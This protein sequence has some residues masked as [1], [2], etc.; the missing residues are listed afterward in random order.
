MTTRVDCRRRLVLGGMLAA[1]VAAAVTLSVRALDPTEADVALPPD[2]ALVPGS[3]LG[4]VEVRVA[5]LLAGDLGQKLQQQLPKESAAARQ[6]VVK[7]IGVA[8]EEVERAVLVILSEKEQIPLAVITTRQPYDREKVLSAVL[9]EHQQRQVKGQTYYFSTKGGRTALRFLTDRVYVSGPVEDVVQQMVKRPTAPAQNPLRP[10]LLLAAQKHLIAAGVHIPEAAAALAKTA[11]DRQ[12][13]NGSF[14]SFVGKSFKPLL[15]VRSVA[16]ALDLGAQADLKVRLI[17]PGADEAKEALWPARD[18]LALARLMLGA[19]IQQAGRQQEFV[20]FVPLL[21]QAQL[22][23]RSATV[24]QQANVLRGAVQLP[25]DA[26]ALAMLVPAVAAA[27]AKTRQSAGRMQSVNNLKQIAL[28]MHNYHDV[29]GTFP[30]HAVYSKD[31]KP[32]LS[33]R[34]MILPY[35]EQ[36]N[37]YKQFRLDEPWDSAHN[38]RLLAQMPRIYA[39]PKDL[40][41]RNQGRVKSPRPQE[42]HYQGFYGKSA[43]FEGKKGIGIASIFDGTSNTIMVV[44][45][46]E[47]VPWTKPQ[48]LPFDPKKP[49]PKLFGVYPQGFN[50]AFCDGSVHFIKDKINPQTL[51]FLITRDG[52]EVINLNDVQ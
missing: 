9:P 26:N 25:A 19:F 42:T 24:E 38:K 34:V 50:A 44:E 11:L 40:P 8:P 3:A 2:L 31:G 32:L 7:H 49:L 46:A 22:A 23:L 4:F 16:L 36:D 37:L 5:D 12:P 45:A 18:G 21:K 27:V 48:D 1:L 28:A 17:F 6:E 15:D 13:D 10:A 39:S 20:P 41:A 52:G 30:P 47:T 33:W 29:Y 35:I 14:E 51:R 43:F